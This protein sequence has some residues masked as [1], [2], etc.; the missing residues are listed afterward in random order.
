MER[1][2]EVLR[3]LDRLFVAELERRP[4]HTEG[5]ERAEVPV[6]LEGIGGVGVVEAHE[7]ARL[8][9]S[10]GQ[11]REM[12]EPDACA[13]IAKQLGGIGCVAGVVEA[14]AFVL[15]KPAAPESGIS[16]SHAATAVVLGWQKGKGEV[17]FLE[18]LPPGKFG[19]G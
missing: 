19:D 16:V 17:A 8:V 9:G 14:E 15:E 1:D 2:G 11:G 10:D 4:V 7:L 6:G 12:E 5:A 18:R 13:D 3:R